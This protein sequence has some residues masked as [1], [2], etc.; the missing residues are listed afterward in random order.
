MA[1]PKA[2]TAAEAVRRERAAFVAG[3][4]YV[5]GERVEDGPE[6]VA[7]ARYPM[8]TVERG[9]VLTLSVND[10]PEDQ[11]RFRATNGELEWASRSI[12]NWGPFWTECDFSDCEPTPAFLAAVADLL[13]SPIEVVPIDEAEAQP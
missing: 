5:C 6:E 13:A 4:S 2:I 8:P 7:A 1:D 12:D 10:D 11:W 3:W 9:R